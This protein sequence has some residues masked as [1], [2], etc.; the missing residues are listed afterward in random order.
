M[1]RLRAC[2]RRNKI[3]FETITAAS[4]SIMAILVSYQSTRIASLQAQLTTLEKLPILRFDVTLEFDPTRNVYHRD[5]LVISNSG[6]AAR[7][8]ESESYIFFEVKYRRDA[9][10]SQIAL[11]PVNG[12]YS[13]S[14]KTKNVTGKLETKTDFAIK[15]GNNF[16][17][18]EIERQFTKLTRER[19]VHSITR[20]VRY[21][22]VTYKDIWGDRHDDVYW[23]DSITTSKLEEADGK[24]IVQEYGMKFTRGQ[25]L[26]LDQASAGSLYEK[27]ALMAAA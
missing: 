27:F 6:A 23:V 22:R 17:A 11:V 10:Q 15:E 3:F 2:L 8:F 13:A 19:G 9:G 7:D 4:L 21:I 26:E 18:A 1:T 20:I 12:Y 14:F 25:F 24:R 16:K 5:T